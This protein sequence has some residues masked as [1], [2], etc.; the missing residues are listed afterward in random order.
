MRVIFQELEQFIN[1]ANETNSTLDKIKVLSKY[2]ELKPI[3]VWIYDTINYQFG[4][5]SA[6]VKKNKNLGVSNFSETNIINVLSQLSSRQYT[7][8]AALMLVNSLIE[9]NP[10]HEELIYNII[11]RNLK[12]RIGV[13]II[14]KVWPGLIPVFD[15]A[16][17][18]SQEDAGEIDFTNNKYYASRKCD[19]VRCLALVNE[20][21]TK[22]FSRQGKEFETLNNLKKAINESKAISTYVLDGEVCL[23]DNQGNENFQG[24]MKEI[25]RK[26]HNIEK[27]V[28]MVFDILNL[29][30]FLKGYFELSFEERLKN[31]H[32]LIKENE[33]IRILEQV[34]I[35]SNP[36]LLVM[37]EKARA[38][39]WEGLILR[40]ASS[41]YE[42]KR[43]KNM[44]KI[45]DFKD[46][47]F[48]VKDLEFGNIRYI[49]NGKEVEEK[50][51]SN[52]FIEYK[53][54]LVGVGSGFSIDQRKRAYH[55]PEF[56]LGK[57]ITVSYFNE[58][59]NE[60]GKYSLRFPTVKAIH[61]EKREI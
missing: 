12:T 21:E 60:H 2:K 14:N 27:P 35:T 30:C 33:N 8:H 57:L 11:D 20:G 56:L 54:N 29:E 15:V 38:L 13:E 1:E 5:T 22:L 47:E 34:L 24:V 10:E 37:V 50:M 41:P 31:L 4:V 36:E 23:V 48:V 46:A 9:K 53:E 43:S 16:L 61:G 3:F 42:G 45:K 40:K 58:S 25:R 39:G 32:Q 49:L 18:V 55:E 28:Y 7:G 17:A 26:N 6:N 59:I 52:V 44:I 51:L 19:G